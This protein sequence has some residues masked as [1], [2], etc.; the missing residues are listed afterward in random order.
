MNRK[1]LAFYGKGQGSWGMGETIEAALENAKR[2]SQGE[3][4]NA[5]VPGLG[6]SAYSV[7]PDTKVLDDGSLKYPKGSTDLYEHRPVKV[8]PANNKNNGNV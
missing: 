8:Y 4:L 2:A 7:H 3:S 1:F 6:W 5:C